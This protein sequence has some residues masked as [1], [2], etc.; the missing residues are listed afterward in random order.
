MEATSTK[1]FV[2]EN[3]FIFLVTFS[4]VAGPMLLVVF[5]NAFYPQWIDDVDLRT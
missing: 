4:F 3:A 2:V 1:S 5:L